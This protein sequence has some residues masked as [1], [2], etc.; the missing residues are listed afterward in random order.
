M[1]RRTFRHIFLLLL[2]VLVYFFVGKFF[3]KVTKTFRII[4]GGL[5]SSRQLAF[6]CVFCVENN[7]PNSTI[8]L[9]S[10][11]PTFYV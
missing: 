6:L 3:W 7:I 11:P 4:R 10:I 5:R 8:R 9:R 2:T 1:V